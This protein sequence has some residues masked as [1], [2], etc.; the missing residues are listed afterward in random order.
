MIAG[1]GVTARLELEAGSPEIGDPILDLVNKALL[2][3]GCWVAAAA[4]IA[5]RFELQFAKLRVWLL[6]LEIGESGNRHCG[7]RQDRT[8]CGPGHAFAD[9]SHLQYSLKKICGYSAGLIAESL[10]DWATGAP[11]GAPPSRISPPIVSSVAA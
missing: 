1:A 8:G 7:E 9:A 2:V 5:D 10:R 11:S 6:D 4:V 3:I